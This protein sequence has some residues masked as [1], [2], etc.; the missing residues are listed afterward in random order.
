MHMRILLI[1]L[2]PLAVGCGCQSEKPTPISPETHQ[3]STMATIIVD[4]LTVCHSDA[5][6][7]LYDTTLGTPVD[8]RSVADTLEYDWAPRPFLR[9]KLKAADST[10]YEIDY[11][12][13]PSCDPN[14]GIHR[15]GLHEKRRLGGSIGTNLSITGD[16]YIYI[17]GR[18]DDYFDRHRKFVVRGDTL[19]EIEQPFYSVGLAST[20]DDTVL[21]FREPSL[22][23]Q[24]ATLIPRDS[25]FV[26]LSLS[27]ER[28]LVR[29]RHG[30]LGWAALPSDHGGQTS[31]PGLFYDGD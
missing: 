28:Y 3:P 1:I 14:F 5:A 31:V 21:L 8:P 13:G 18:A 29:D 26:V 30:I 12:P 15:V 4:S 24:V 9:T 25:I 16:G 22:I 6:T 11:S 10:L 27:N 23:H 17:S 20:V 19:V 7:I 2:L